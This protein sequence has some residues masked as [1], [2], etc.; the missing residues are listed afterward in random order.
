[1]PQKRRIHL[2]SFSPDIKARRAQEHPRVYTSVEIA[3][4]FTG[5]QLKPEE[6]K[7]LIELSLNKYCPVAAMVKKTEKFNKG[8][9]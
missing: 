3:Y 5:K 9:S 2:K 1:M 7:N 6:L 4:K 8:W